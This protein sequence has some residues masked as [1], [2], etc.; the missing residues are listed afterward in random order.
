MTARPG[1]VRRLVALAAV[2]TITVTL[3]L[4]GTAGASLAA[5]G[6]KGFSA[7]ETISRVHSDG[8]VD[9][10]VDTRTVSLSVSNTANLRSRQEIKVSW[11]GAHPTG[12]IYSD[13]NS[14]DA[15]H[16]EYPVVLLECRGDAAHVSPS[17]CW[18]QSWSERV[19][20]ASVSAPPFP[21]W[22]VDRYA[23]ASERTS[24][25]GVPATMP[26]NCF[27]GSAAAQRWVPFVAANKVVYPIGEGGCAG[28]PAESN[29]AGGGSLPSNTTYGVTNTDG[30]GSASF[31][32]WTAEDNASLGCS[33]AVACTL[34]AVPVM[35]VSC[36]VDAAA[37]PDADRPA[38]GEEA[39]DAKAECE[40]TGKYGPGELAQANRFDTA[41]SGTLWW[42]ASNWK[43]RIAVPLSFA[44]SSN[45]CDV[46]NHGGSVDLYG[47]ELAI[48]A[49]TQW[50][51]TFCLDPKLFKFKHI[52]TGEP[53]ARTLLANSSINAALVSQPG[54]TKYTRPVVNAPVAAS[55]FVIA[56]AI[57]DLKRHKVTQLKLTP[58]LLAK[59]MTE[60]YPAEL[61]VR[62]DYAALPDTD[63]TGK[64]TPLKALVGN[65]LNMAADPEFQALNP[66]LPTSVTTQGA[67]T[68]L[69]LGSNS[70]VI[71]AL[72]SY[73][74]ADPETRTW[75]DG[76][77]DPWGMV[78]NPAY[79][80]I[81]LPLDSW[82]LLDSFV[83]PSI[84][85][86]NVNDCLAQNPVPFLPLVASPVSRMEAITLAM[87]FSVLNSQTICTQVGETNAG[88]K[89]VAQGRQTIGFRFMLGVT[90]M[91]DAQRYGLA[92]ASLQTAVSSSAAAKFTSAAG[93][94]FVAPSITSLKA[95]AALLTPDTTKNMWSLPYASLHSEAK[96]AGAYPGFMLIYVAAPTSGVTPA[97]E[98]PQLATLIRF[99]STRGQTP[100]SG[101]GQL[102]AG[103]L[104]L[105]AANGLGAQAAYAQTAATAI[106]AQQGTVPSVLGDPA[107]AP[108]A[109]ADT[110]TTTDVSSGVG[111]SD[112][113]DT[114]ADAA[115]A[116]AGPSP[117]ASEVSGLQVVALGRTQTQA[118][119]V[120]GAFLPVALGVSLLCLVAAPAWAYWARRRAAR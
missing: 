85:N 56:F 76:T 64:P 100:G 45:V 24:K 105:T 104:P 69:S 108:V 109:S 59:L 22:R 110:S 81:S 63:S 20:V 40:A 99:A 87:Q 44:P 98:G 19:Q 43:N 61:S 39:D 103:F 36:D 93:R 95:A 1:R 7:R 42:A 88:E 16:E 14:S 35:G 23:L 112:A 115:P 53:Q 78:V 80:G 25:V 58:R 117:S 107:P 74:D 30:T 28:M 119:G 31:D 12:G 9:T 32:I 47:S 116:A 90:S 38:A 82:P 46:V 83:P 18:T 97:A 106:A 55:G 96:A 118:S 50:A 101:N 91:G 57:D 48:Q 89:L 51:P 34:V 33:Q 6:D 92:T 111:G 17:T 3:G 102:P 13:Q 72:T 27:S 29:N 68:I 37:L 84:E 77:P 71:R 26:A 11:T 4:L 10:V 49:T 120:A 113:A 65:P 94:T 2:G 8:G 79:K 75:L 62:N 21:A 67:A 114:P 54:S 15:Q 66:G 41:V 86:V 60:S 73:L 5:T 52:Q 70:D